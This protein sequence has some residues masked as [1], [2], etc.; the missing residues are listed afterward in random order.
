MVVSDWIRHHA[1]VLELRCIQFASFICR[2]PFFPNFHRCVTA[3]VRLLSTDKN[4]SIG[5][6]VR[7]KSPYLHLPIEVKKSQIGAETVEQEFLPAAFR[8]F[9]WDSW[10]H[11]AGEIEWYGVRKADIKGEE[12]PFI[13][14]FSY[15]IRGQGAHTDHYGLR[16]AEGVEGTIW[17]LRNQTIVSMQ[18]TPLYWML[19]SSNDTYNVVRIENT[20]LAMLIVSLSEIGSGNPQLY[21]KAVKRLEE[22]ANFKLEGKSP[23]KAILEFL[24]HIRDWGPLGMEP[25]FAGLK[26]VLERMGIADKERILFDFYADNWGVR[27]NHHGRLLAVKILEVLGTAKAL[28]ALESISNYMKNQAVTPNEIT[29]IRIAVNKV[30]EKLESTPT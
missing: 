25:V 20:E 16:L 24:R 17:V 4:I 29:L 8:F 22:W 13:T 15:K 23:E 1:L 19:E 2:V 30:R 26:E 5:F 7:F 9:D 21:D 11:L 12:V 28:I 27:N 18:F 10:V 14:G 6:I 3:D